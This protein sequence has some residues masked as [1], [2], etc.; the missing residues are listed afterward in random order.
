[1]EVGVRT[2]GREGQGLSTN[3]R[4]PL[5]PPYHGRTAHEHEHAGVLLP[6]L[7][8]PLPK[9]PPPST[10]AAEKQLQCRLPEQR[11]Q[12]LPRAPR[13]QSAVP[14]LSHMARSGGV[15]S[16]LLSGSLLDRNA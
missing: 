5:Q 7:G 4:P 15:V 11:H 6:C 8:W 3:P 12:E 16:T 2:A 1:M 13:A 14:A 10:S 9:G